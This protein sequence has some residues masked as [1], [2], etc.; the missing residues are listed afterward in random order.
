M[1][2]ATIQDD[3]ASRDETYSTLQ[4][5]NRASRIKVCG[6]VSRVGGWVVGWVAE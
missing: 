2:V 6:C 4:F 3:P 1:L 5:A